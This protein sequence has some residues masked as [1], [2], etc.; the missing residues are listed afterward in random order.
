MQENRNDKILTR[1]ILLPIGNWDMII[2]GM[3]TIYNTS[4]SEVLNIISE[5]IRKGHKIETASDLKQV[6]LKEYSKKSGPE[7]TVDIIS[8]YFDIE[9][10]NIF[11]SRRRGILGYSKQITIFFLYYHNQ[12][13]KKE[14]AKMFSIK[15]TSIRYAIKK[16][17]KYADLPVYKKD[18]K[19]ISEQL[20]AKNIYYKLLAKSLHGNK[21]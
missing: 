17:R 5:Y 9:K 2:K 21:N 14:I 6:L 19:A 4:V 8:Y 15:A 18:I 7:L 1:I 16:V 20:G 13:S 11:I 12:L 10:K 3:A